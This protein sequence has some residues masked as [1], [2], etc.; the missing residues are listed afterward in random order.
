[1]IRKSF[2]IV[3]AVSI[4]RIISRYFMSLYLYRAVP[5]RLSFWIN[6]IFLLI[7]L[8]DTCTSCDHLF[9]LIACLSWMEV[10]FLNQTPFFHHSLAFSNLVFFSVILNESM[11]IFAFGHSSSPFNSF[12][13]LLILRPFVM[14][15][16]LPYLA[17]RFFCFPCIRL[18]VCLHAI[19]P[20]LLVGFFSLFCNV[21][22]YLYCFTLSRYLFKHHSFASN[23][24]FISF[25]CIVIFT[26]GGARGVM[27]IVVGNGY[28]DTSSNPGQDWLHFR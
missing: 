7:V 25:S 1:M 23:F 16:W 10:I 19:F 21:L 15:S 2:S 18:C 28:G 17:Q 13:I 9:I 24:C 26:C 27:V 8:S 20:Y 11:S 5:L 4:F 3:C 6:V 14:F 22:F 12:P